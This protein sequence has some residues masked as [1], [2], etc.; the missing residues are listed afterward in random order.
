MTVPFQMED[1]LV[2]PRTGSAMRRVDGAFVSTGDSSIR[3]PIEGGIIKALI[4]HHP[5]GYNALDDIAAFYEHNPFP[6]YDD[7][8]DVGSLLEKSV[9]Q[10]FPE[11]LNRSIPPNATILEA[12][13][14]TGQ[15]GN[16][17]SIVG[18]H[19]L[20]FDVCLNSLRL[21]Q[22]FKEKNGLNSVTFAQMNLFRLPLRPA[23][24]D[25]LIC[26]GVL[27][28]TE[29]PAAGFRNLLQYLKPGG[30]IVVG[31]YNRYGR[32]TTRLRRG[33]FRLVGQSAW[34]L[35][36]YL[37][38]A[39]ISKEKR[40]VW[41]MDQYRNP[42]ESL[43][44]TDEVLGWFDAA[45][46]AFVRALPST[47]FGARFELHY[48]HSLFQPEGRGSCVDRLLSQLKQM[49]SDTEGGLFIMIG[50]KR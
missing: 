20:S 5:D 33:V 28:H 22:R 48:N 30:K 18:R 6:N 42:H 23:S 16:F 14:G 26:T 27:H 37:R 29:N 44:T 46:L 7:M 2:C 50:A 47:V 8:D 41:F 24:F 39:C 21:A 43:H 3:F 34:R 13:C 17:L 12:G 4:P 45:Q 15:L 35:D 31:L 11:M 1:L 38:K 49:I 9:S 25:I 40:S 19:V 32:L 10:G 36:P